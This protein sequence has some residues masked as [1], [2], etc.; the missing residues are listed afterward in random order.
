[1]PSADRPLGE[2]FDTVAEA[3][4]EIREGYGTELVARAVEL[5]GLGR[6]SRVLEIGCGT[7]KLTEVLVEFGLRVDAIDPGARMIAVAER[8]V[9]PT[10]RVVFHIG[11]F[12]DTPLP[13]AGFD[14]AFSATAFHW[15]DARISW[16]KA[17]SHLRPGGLLALLTHTSMRDERS[18]ESERAFRKLL[19]KYAPAVTEGWPP[20]RDLQTLLAGAE[21]RSGNASEVWDWVMG[22][23]RHDLA[24]DAAAQWFEAVEVRA[25][26]SDVERTADELLAHFR[27]TSLYFQIEPDKRQAFEA[28]DRR[29]I[30]AEG[31]SVHFSAAIVLM[32][33]RRSGAP[34][35][36]LL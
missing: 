10:D 24:S 22:D 20:P 3:Y 8:R 5:G 9:G 19:R 30:E 32:T 11:R 12:E 16:T 23:G 13:S 18:I 2:E 7:G 34:V 4:D 26:V 36:G 33:A 31:G 27:T 1:M 21:A 15:L 25:V 35:T 28:E 29:R 17:A 6:D 14:A